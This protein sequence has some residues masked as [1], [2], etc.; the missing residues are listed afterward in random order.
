MEPKNTEQRIAELEKRVTQIEQCI[1]DY[2]LKQVK[3]R[4]KT[5]E[6]LD[7]IGKRIAYQMK[8][9]GISQKELSNV[10]E[11]PPSA[12]SMILSGKRNINIKKLAILS[13]LLEVSTDYLIFGEDEQNALEE[14]PKV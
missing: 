13:K 11:V 6:K 4:F 5:P 8:Q 1:N 14:S 10:F 3:P 9:K 2:A 12:I 7:T